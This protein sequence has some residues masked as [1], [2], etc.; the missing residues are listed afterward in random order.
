MLNRGVFT[1]INGCVSTGKEANVYHASALSGDSL[2]VKVYKT[3]I[4][5]FKDRERYGIAAACCGFEFH[6]EWLC[7]Q[8]C[9]K[10]MQESTMAAHPA[11][12]AC[13]LLPACRYVKGDFRFRKGYSKSNPRKMVK[14]WAEKEMRNL[15]RL[16]AAGIR[17]P[18]AHQLQMH[19][20]VM[21]FIGSGDV[22]A[23]RLTDADLPLVRDSDHLTCCAMH[24]SSTRF[25]SRVWSCDGAHAGR[26][27]QSR[28][29]EAA[30]LLMS[31]NASLRACSRGCGAPTARCC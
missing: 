19:V 24:G 12:A 7:S 3:S 26:L 2:A 15:I 27:L 8:C 21:S 28:H 25:W 16:A 1:E 10:S 17:C 9:M 31:L 5:V 29:H 4:L 23:P 11:T 14:V 18:V 20:L 22:A 13:V 30:P 6:L